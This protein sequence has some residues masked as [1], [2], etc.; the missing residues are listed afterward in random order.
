MSS[1][2]QIFHLRGILHSLG[3]KGRFSAE[4][5]KR[6]KEERELQEELTFIQETA[7]NMGEGHRQGV[8][9]RE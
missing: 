8:R 3:M 7:K 4:K 9:R 2:K 1:T 6:I 5:A